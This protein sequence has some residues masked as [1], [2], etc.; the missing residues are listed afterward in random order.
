[1]FYCPIKPLTPPIGPFKS[2]AFL[3]R[4]SNGG[5][6]ITK[7]WPH[8]EGDRPK[9]SRVKAENRRKVQ[10]LTARDKMCLEFSL[11]LNFQIVL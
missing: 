3:V 7:G 1:M 5:I 8:R 2:L 10:K 9:E 11:V 6:K 4:G